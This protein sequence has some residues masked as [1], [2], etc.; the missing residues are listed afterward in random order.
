MESLTEELGLH[1][2]VK[3]EPRLQQKEKREVE[4][5]EWGEADGV[6][7]GAGPEGEGGWCLVS[8]WAGVA[9]RECFPGVGNRSTVIC[10]GAHG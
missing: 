10:K 1:R 9:G 3:G 8:G 6:G 5:P 7:K 4:G 2:A